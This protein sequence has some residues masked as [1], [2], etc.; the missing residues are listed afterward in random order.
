[1]PDA[2]SSELLQRHDIS[3]DSCLSCITTVSLA[4]QAAQNGDIAAA[5]A[6][7]FVAQE[8]MAAAA[9]A[10]LKD[11]NAVRNHT[12]SVWLLC[13]PVHPFIH[14]WLQPASRPNINNTDRDC[15]ICGLAESIG[16]AGCI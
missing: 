7:I 2:G 3:C 9:A 1:M 12:N 13:R 4:E 10:L 8:T 14:P 16:Y 11:A 5:T 15:I 6:A